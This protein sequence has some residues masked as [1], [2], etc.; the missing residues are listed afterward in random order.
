MSVPVKAAERVSQETARK[1]AAAAARSAA[2]R[3]TERTA[4]L[5]AK[6]TLRHTLARLVVPL[7]TVWAAWTVV[8]IAGPAFRKT[9]P[10]VT[11]IALLRRLQAASSN[12]P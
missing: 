10:A 7:G 3:G 8:D 5:A 2:R 1:A 11:Y 9:M 12:A 6:H 4:E